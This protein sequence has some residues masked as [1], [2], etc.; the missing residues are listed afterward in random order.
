MIDSPAVRWDFFCALCEAFLNIFLIFFE[1]WSLF[2]IFADNKKNGM[3]LTS[4][5]YAK[6]IMW[7]ADNKRHIILGKTQ[8]Q[9]IL[10]VCY[11]LYLV[12][13]NDNPQCISQKLFA[14]DTP[15]AWPFGPVFPRSYKRHSMLRGILMEEEKVEFSKDKET[16]YEI[17]HITEKLCGLS[18]KD[19]TRWS[20][21]DDTPWDKALFGEGKKLKWGVVISDE[22]IYDYFKGSEW[23]IGLMD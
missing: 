6:L 8:L 2:C 18:A 14:D 19:L 4:L 13:H 15:K 12:R 20:H 1:G 11:G 9:K 10:F 16:L 5:H 3:E 22:S 21:Q 17:W 23:K 7:L